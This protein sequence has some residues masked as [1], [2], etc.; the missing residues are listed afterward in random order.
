MLEHIN[1]LGNWL[2]AQD[3]AEGYKERI[4]QLRQDWVEAETLLESA[5]HWA[6]KAGV[7]D[8]YELNEGSPPY[9][10]AFEKISQVSKAWTQLLSDMEIPYTDPNFP[11]LTLQITTSTQ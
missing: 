5:S 3:G 8:K 10:A 11:E 4:F 6:E 1:K 2:L 9:K 7:G